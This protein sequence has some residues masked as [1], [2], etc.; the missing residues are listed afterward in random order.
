MAAGLDAAAILFDAAGNELAKS[1]VAGEGADEVVTFDGVT[2]STSYY[3]TVLSKDYATEGNFGVSV[4][5]GLIRGSVAGTK[6]YDLNQDGLHDLNEP[7]L[8]GWVI[9]ADENSDGQLSLAGR[10]EP[11]AYGGGTL[12]DRISPAVVLSAVGEGVISHQVTAAFGWPTSTGSKLFNNDWTDLPLWHEEVAELRADFLVPVSQVS[13]DFVADS[14]DDVG[15]LEAY[16]TSGNLLESYTTAPLTD[17]FFETMT[18]VRQTADIA[19]VKAFG[20]GDRI[21][22][23]DRLVFGAGTA[24]VFDVTNSLG[25]Y[26]LVDLPLATY[27]IREILQGAW[28][29]TSPVV[30]SHSV[31]LSVAAP[32]ATDLDFGNFAAAAD[33]R[34]EVGRPG[35][36]L[37]ARRGRARPGR[38][39]DLSRSQ[40]EWTARSGR[41][42]DAHQHPGRVLVCR[43]RGRQLRRRRSAAAELGANLSS[44]G[45]RVHQRR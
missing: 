18:I 25:H 1:Y 10:I 29:P 37:C 45:H 42:S 12:L 26:T 44:G 24:E 30:G 7:G 4:A 39:D 15:R 28:V 33:P 6:F 5:F 9:Y 17:E 31:E 38:L 19:Y 21:G 14:D 34:C 41:T 40:R 23:L 32:N 3:L 13:I 22:R 20:A 2:P 16:D 36:R 27:Q 11:D 43:A 8:E 35:R